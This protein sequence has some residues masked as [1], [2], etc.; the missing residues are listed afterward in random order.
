MTEDIQR[1]LDGV[2]AQFKVLEGQFNEARA[3][4]LKAEIAENEIAVRM[5]SV[6]KVKASLRSALD[7]SRS[8]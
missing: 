8:A 2:E 4:R 7:A 6:V 5:V 1:I 3:A